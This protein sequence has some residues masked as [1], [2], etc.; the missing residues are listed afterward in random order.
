MRVEMCRRGSGCERNFKR[1]T[2]TVIE[3]KNGSDRSSS[4][5]YAHGFLLITRELAPESLFA[6]SASER[7]GK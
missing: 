2:K 6:P 5:S 4:K 1:P 3:F 7:Q